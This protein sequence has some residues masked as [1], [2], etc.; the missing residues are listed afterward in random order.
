MNRLL[1]AISVYGF[2]EENLL[3]LYYESF[4]RAF[5]G[6]GVLFRV[7]TTGEDSDCH[8]IGELV[9]FRN[10]NYE[11]THC[12]RMSV[13]KSDSSNSESDKEHN[14][15]WTWNCL[16]S[17][18]WEWNHWLRATRCRQD[19]DCARVG[20]ILQ[21]ESLWIVKV[22][23]YDILLPVDS[24]KASMVPFFTIRGEVSLGRTIGLALWFLLEAFDSKMG[25]TISK[26]ALDEWE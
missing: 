16:Q 22:E 10:A 14:L 1:Q 18:R 21:F 7:I 15:R 3:F 2:G 4:S 20:L 9:S 17:D 5:L 6:G 25:R 24:P 23:T 19:S 11:S 26:K 13:S 8:W 12:H